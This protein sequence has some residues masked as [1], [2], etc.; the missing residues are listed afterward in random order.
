MAQPDKVTY[1]EIMRELAFEKMIEQGLNDVKT[2]RVISEEVA[3]GFVYG[4]T[5]VD[6]GRR[7]VADRVRERK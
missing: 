7:A 1:E 6:K 2:G 3:T 5:E 4:M